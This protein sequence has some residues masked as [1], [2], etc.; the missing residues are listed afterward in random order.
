MNT[1]M[2]PRAMTYGEHSL[3]TLVQTDTQKLLQSTVTST[4][5]N[6][7]SLNH[8]LTTGLRVGEETRL[9][10][11]LNTVVLVTQTYTKENQMKQTALHELLAVETGLSET[12]NRVQK[13]TTKTLAT[14]ETI[15]AGMVK[16]HVLFDESLQHLTQATESKEVQ[17]TATEQLD[18]AATEIAR[19][20]DVTLQ[21]ED[22]NQKAKAD[23]VVGDTVIA[24]DIPAIVLLSMEKKLTSLLALYNALP[25]LDASKSWIKA[26]GYP[27]ANVFVTKNQRENQQSITEKT[28]VE[29]SP[30]TK[31]FKAQLVQ[32]EKTT[33]VGK[34][35][36][37]EFS[38]ALT[39]LDKAEKIQRLTA[40]IRAVKTA[41][42]RANTQVVDTTKKFADSIFGYING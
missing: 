37:D 3:D 34:F 22:A 40:T 18:Y 20:W 29:V 13:E 8:W 11:I 39:S 10:H 41:R 36:I 35:V 42:Q 27:V 28:W 7:T 19:Y 14:K 9:P 4:V 16:A 17:S 12:A 23:I 30:A 2:C 25:T 32:Q 38:G 26:E 21:K 6:N 5:Q 24:K 15:F 33:V 1:E 31:E